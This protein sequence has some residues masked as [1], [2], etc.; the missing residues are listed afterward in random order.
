MGKA[1]SIQAALSVTTDRMFCKDVGDL[2]EI[3]NYITGENL[4]THQL[5]RAARFAKPFIL[6]QHPALADFTPESIS[7]SIET[8]G[9]DNAYGEIMRHASNAVGGMTIELE[10]APEGVSAHK[11]PIEEL[12]EMRGSA[13][14]IMVIRQ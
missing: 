13:D 9:W 7:A 11:D 6:A 3:L 1:F 10:P 12:I 4:M 14:G 2:Y 8:N 5:P